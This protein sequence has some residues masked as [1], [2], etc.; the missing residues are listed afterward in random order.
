[1]DVFDTKGY[2]KYDLETLLFF[3]FLSSESSSDAVVGVYILYRVVHSYSSLF[4]SF[5][6]VPAGQV[7]KNF[8][9]SVAE[10]TIKEPKPYAGRCAATPRATCT[11][12]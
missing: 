2:G 10:H 5:V 12:C 3:I 4:F 6:P 7:K 11:A 9:L 1:M 8:L